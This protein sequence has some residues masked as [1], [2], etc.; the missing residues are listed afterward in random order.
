MA[1]VNDVLE[2]ELRLGASGFEDIICASACGMCCHLERVETPDG[3]KRRVIV[4]PKVVPTVYGFLFWLLSTAGFGLAV[5]GGAPS[6]PET[7]PTFPVVS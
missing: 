4:P 6:L 5:A 1:H 3:S 7:S 2:D